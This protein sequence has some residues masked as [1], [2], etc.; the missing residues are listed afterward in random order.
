V[1]P[2]GFSIRSVWIFFGITVVLL[3][4]LFP[5][6]WMLATSLKQPPDILTQPP[7]WVFE[8]TLD[9]YRFVFERRNF[10]HFFQNSIIAAATSSFIVMLLGG[11][12]AYGIVRYR[13]GRQ[14]LMFFI[15]TFRMFPPIAVVIPF[16]IIF[17]TLHLLDTRMALVIAYTVM[18]L[19]LAVWLMH[20]FVRDI[21]VAVEEAAYIDGY[22]RWQ[23]LRRVVAPLAAPGL[24]VT[25][26]LSFLFAWNEFLFAFILTRTRTATVTLGVSSFITQEGTLWGPLAASAVVAVLP[27][28][29]LVMF[30]QRYIARGLTFGAVKG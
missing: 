21:P 1:E 29:I 8:P 3:F 22:S 13:V 7:R 25:F 26:M 17:R 9:N 2:R 19:P 24:A 10:L 20:S 15:L 16:F 30:L 12:T 23:A 5:I 14:P 6:Y 18:N 28:M 4:F 11:L 27:M